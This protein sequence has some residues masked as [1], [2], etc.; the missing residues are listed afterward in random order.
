MCL[1]DRIPLVG[2]SLLH[3]GNVPTLLK[4]FEVTIVKSLTNIVVI[5]VAANKRCT[6]ETVH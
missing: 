6:K 4:V 2:T 1:F 5:T 3:I